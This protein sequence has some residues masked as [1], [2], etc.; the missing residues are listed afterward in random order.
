MNAPVFGSLRRGCLGLALVCSVT[1]ARG[2]VLP[3][4][5]GS[6]RPTDETLY[7][8]AVSLIADSAIHRLDFFPPRAQLRVQLLFLSPRDS[9]AAVFFEIARRSDVSAIQIDA[10]MSR[11]E[12][13]PVP[14]DLH[15]LNRE[16]LTSLRT[17]R[18]A[19][20]H[21]G[22]AAKACQLDA[23]SVARCQG[24]FTSASRAVATAYDHYLSTR[25][26]I[27]RQITDTQTILPA[28]VVSSRR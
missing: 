19:L 27:A 13:M 22:A 17:A 23:T 12:H 26:R 9:S 11:F 18:G 20:D 24:P 15:E 16:L 5:Q 8:N 14:D 7:A 4:Q 6:A 21:L 1:A 2:P 10:T 25:A 3:A 28:F